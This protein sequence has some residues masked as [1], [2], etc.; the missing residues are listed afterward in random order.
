MTAENLAA[1]T[2]SLVVIGAG[3][4]GRNLIRNLADMGELAA[5]VEPFAANQAWVRE[6]FPAVP[7]H[8]NH[9]ALLQ[10]D[11][12]KG[13]CIAT[14]AHTHFA[15]AKDFIEAGKDAFVE[16]PITTSSAEA[17]ALCE[18]A[19]KHNRIVMTGHLLIYQPAI[20]WLKEYLDSGALGQL[21]SLHQRR[22]D[23]GR[24]TQVENALWALGVHDVAVLLYLIGQA[25]TQTTTHAHGA[26]R[27]AVAEDVYVHM[28]FASGLRAH[29]HNSWLWPVKERRLVVVGERG[30][31]TYDELAQTITLNK[32]V[33]HA[34]LSQSD[35]GSE[36][37][38]TGHGQPLRL[39][40]EHFVECIRTRT[41]PKTSG[42]SAVEVI[43]VL[44]S[45]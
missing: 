11:R 27:A 20:S 19:E 29:L 37:L 39:E 16:K 32:R 28:T 1:T 45:C 21:Y 9:Q 15:L 17:I 22:A 43:K 14:P 41:T 6:H 33:I 7:L 44:E 25:P 34:D 4:W 36:L 40:L 26:L 13:A 42:R 30:M 5:I 3:N 10:D 38:Y 2:P 18:L 8:D 12:I 31:L 23:L 35:D 24:A